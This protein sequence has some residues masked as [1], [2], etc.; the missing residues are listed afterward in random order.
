MAGL[1][2]NI[3]TVGIKGIEGHSRTL[4]CIVKEQRTLL[5]RGILLQ[6]SAV[7]VGFEIHSSVLKDY[8][9][10][11]ENNK[12]VTMTSTKVVIVGAGVAG[13]TAAAWLL[14][15]GV[16]D[17]V[18]LEAQDY[19]GGRVKAEVVDGKNLDLGAQFV[20]GKD[21]N[22][23]YDI[24]EKIGLAIFPDNSANNYLVNTPAE[25][26]T[27]H[28][29]KIPHEEAD[30]LVDFL[31][32]RTHKEAVDDLDIDDRGN[33][34]GE[35]Y[36]KAYR[37][38][39]AKYGRN[40]NRRQREVLNAV[41]N[42]FCGYQTIDTAA[43]DLTELSE[44]ALRIYKVLPGPRFAYV[45]GGITEILKAIVRLLP[46]EMIRLNTPVLNIDWS[47][48]K[49]KPSGKVR[50]TCDNGETILADHVIV[51]TSIG[52]LQA[53]HQELF[54]PNLPLPAQT[55]ISNLGFG[56]I[57]KI[58]IKWDKPFVGYSLSPYGEVQTY[59]F[60]WLDS[61]SITLPSDR[62]PL[63][64]RYGKPWWY[65]VHTAETVRG[66]P[67]ILELWVN[68]FQAEIMEQ[69]DET[70]LEAVCYELV[71]V[72]FK[73]L[74]IPKPAA[75]IR[76]KWITNPYFRGTYSFISSKV[77][78]QDLKNLGQ[79]LPSESNPRVLFAGEGY[80]NGFISTI[81]G[82]L[83]TGQAQAELIL[84]TKGTQPNTTRCYDLFTCFFT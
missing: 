7:I 82:A 76:T 40:L 55:A 35:C 20:H 78:K 43:A 58:F 8:V 62:C 11:C 77:R 73:D 42:W 70:E 56:G 63:K 39:L 19:I 38:Y 80:A 33:S 10:L 1:W 74:K 81:H 3:E 61:K 68:K 64:T 65:G 32:E 4:T 79:P 16:K 18:I 6:S 54:T 50:V 28:G 27:P 84:K 22:P 48:M 75:I 37:E 26:R 24:A 47:E 53:K 51:T 69:L 71:Q 83:L 66:C 30:G 23:A 13:V 41:Y 21:G 17:V 46:R 14:K 2:K 60:L 31:F 12:R 52:F 5:V 36:E 67:N 15:H 25:F 34:E 49:S 45:E 9:H 59:D 44:W 29:E 57:G 72:L